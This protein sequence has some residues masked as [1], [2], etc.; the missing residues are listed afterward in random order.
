MNLP[1]TEKELINLKRYA[2]GHLQKKIHIIEVIDTSFA[3]CGFV[4]V[5]INNSFEGWPMQPSFNYFGEDILTFNDP[6]I[7][8]Q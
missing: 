8:K 6:Q 7:A 1:T 5:F 2:D 3:L 4:P